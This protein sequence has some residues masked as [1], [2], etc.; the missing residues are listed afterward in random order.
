MMISQQEKQ[1]SSLR[2][3]VRMVESLITRALWIWQRVGHQTKNLNSNSHTN[4][5]IS[6]LL[7]EEIKLRSMLIWVNIK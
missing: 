6:G 4:H 2:Q 5:T 7:Q 1:H 3:Q